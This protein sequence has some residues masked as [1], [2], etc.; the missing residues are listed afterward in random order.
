MKQPI[1]QHIQPNLVEMNGIKL[2][3]KFSSFS[4][5]NR[6]TERSYEFLISKLQTFLKES[7]LDL[8]N[9][10]RLPRKLETK[11]PISI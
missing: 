6:N 7:Y 5:K 9:Y 8:S 10:M 11:M 4:K 3:V 2:S 1:L